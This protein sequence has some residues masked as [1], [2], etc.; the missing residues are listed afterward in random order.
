MSKDELYEMR[1]K[2]IDKECEGSA[3]LYERKIR[4][5]LQKIDV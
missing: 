4:E 2:E 1:K 3:E 5:L